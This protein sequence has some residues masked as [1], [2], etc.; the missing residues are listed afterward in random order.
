MH[1]SRSLFAQALRHGRLTV[2][3]RLLPFALILL[4]LL[5]GGLAPEGTGGVP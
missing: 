2:V 4:G 1:I 3:K 5:A